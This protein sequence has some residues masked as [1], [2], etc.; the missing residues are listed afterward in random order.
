MPRG[1]NLLQVDASSLAGTATENALNDHA[2]RLLQHPSL[3]RL[4]PHVRIP[5]AFVHF[6]EVKV[7]DE[8]AV[9]LEAVLA[10]HVGDEDVCLVVPRVVDGSC[11]TAPR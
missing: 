9:V 2:C 4:S 1:S 5:A 6:D 7:G 3:P 11:L 10:D 8:A